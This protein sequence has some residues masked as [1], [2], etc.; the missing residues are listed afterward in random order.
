MSL[1][2]G[3]AVWR[4][5]T[6]Y[7]LMAT[8]MM[9]PFD[10]NVVGPALPTIAERFGLS[11][12]RTGLVISMFAIPGIVAGPI[13]GILAD[14][15]GRRRV[16]IPCL[17]IYGLAGVSILAVESFIGVLA[18]RFVQ[19]LVGGSILA[20]LA[21]TI[22]GDVYDGPTQNTV[23]GM[24]SAAITVTAA[25]APAIGG[26]LAAI[27]WDAPF[28]VYGL[29]VVV[30]GAVYVWLEEPVRERES[31][32]DLGYLRE[33]LR[34]VPTRP[35]LGLYGANFASFALYFGG[36]LT[37]ASFLLSDAYGLG[38]ARIGSLITGAMLV[39]ALVAIL[40][41]RFVRIAS[42]E[43]LISLGFVTY[44]IGLIGTWAAGSAGDVLGA[45]VFFGIG[46][47][48]VLPSVASGLAGLAPTEFRGGVMSLRTSLVLT[49]QAV[50]PPLFTVP[51]D[52]I[53]YSSVL[54]T[55]GGVA[56]VGG[57]GALLTL[58]YR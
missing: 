35:A 39:S 15:Y 34:V 21:L 6:A 48:L 46:H 17:L 51:A 58:R 45:L 27:A 20:S 33:A 28:A 23:M 44:G 47:G 29:S 11:D 4:E 32:L 7:L 30:A 12:A 10:V 19:G 26:A 36:V 38:S 41:G 9:A 31:T 13:I 55:A 18:L 37:A 16:V 42:E 25:L 3:R 52:V 56:F 2:D 1:G 22:V 50:A 8:A 14:R 40:N 49:S 5:P 57:V 53:G 54:L 43:Q 24:T